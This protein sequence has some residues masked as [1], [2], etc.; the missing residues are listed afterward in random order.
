LVG[1][2]TVEIP[3]TQLTNVGH[4]LVNSLYGDGQ[5]TR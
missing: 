5:M 2:R 3:D 1:G 4:F